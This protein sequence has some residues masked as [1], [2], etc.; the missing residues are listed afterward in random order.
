MPMQLMEVARR[1][2]GGLAPVPP[3]ND[4]ALAAFSGL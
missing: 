2:H 3:N 4:L 1:K